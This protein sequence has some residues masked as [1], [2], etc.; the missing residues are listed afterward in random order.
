MPHAEVAGPDPISPPALIVVTG[1]NGFIASHTVH[2]L[3]RAGFRVLATVRSP[4][5]AEI[6]RKTHAQLLSE[7][8]TNELL[9]TAVV[10]DITDPDAYTALFSSSEPL[11]VIHL[12]SP[13]GYSVAD[14]ERDLMRP[15][16]RGT[17]AVLK[18]VSV[19]PSVRRVVHTNS[20]ACMYDA[21]LGPRPGYTY[22][23][24]DWCPLT[25]EDGVAASNAPVAYRASKVVA[26]KTS[27]S[28]MEDASHHFDLVSLC[29]AMVF[30]PFLD[31][32]YSL[33][34]SPDDLNT[35][36]RLVWD[37]VS[38]GEDAPVPMTKGPVWID[39]RD[40]AEAHVKALGLTV[41]NDRRRLLLA[42]GVYCN[43]EIAD[44]ARQV[45]DSKLR[46]RVARGTPGRREADTHFAVD[47]SEEE[48]ALLTD[49]HDQG[50]KTQK[51]WRELEETMADLLP[52]LYRIEEQAKKA[53]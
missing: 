49:K 37:V 1:A 42:K 6:V 17:E 7:N 12:A 36:N 3:L 26:E 20:F 15:A 18:A 13:F 35:S 45:L 39:V 11:A 5:K 43:Q 21:A 24:K 25:F 8:V 14:Y 31:T 9:S 51:K 52:Q 41:C 4:K 48:A 32:E 22:T 23:S 38:V 40:V 29:P 46:P 27:W 33:P 53:E 16:V 19:T 30:G 34:A 47:A 44:V 10:A 28:F 2:L 50:V